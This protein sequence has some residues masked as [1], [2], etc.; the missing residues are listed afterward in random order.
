MANYC[1]RKLKQC[2][3]LHGCQNSEMFQPWM[4]VSLP[5][6]F[7]FFEGDLK[8]SPGR[9]LIARFYLMLNFKHRSS[10]NCFQIP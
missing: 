7:H 9:F 1:G 10:R 8:F 4:I 6:G 5:G 2:D 3:H